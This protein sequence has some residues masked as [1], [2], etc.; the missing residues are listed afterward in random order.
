MVERTTC[1][2]IVS[3][4]EKGREATFPVSMKLNFCEGTNAFCL[5]IYV[6]TH[7]S[8]RESV[9]SVKLE[10]AKSTMK[11]NQIDELSPVAL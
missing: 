6:G 7:Y 3:C 4:V 5:F 9:E 1:L 10:T 11:R 8:L 2:I